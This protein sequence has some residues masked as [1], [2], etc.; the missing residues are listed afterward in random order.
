MCSLLLAGVAG[1]NEDLRFGLGVSRPWD[2]DGMRRRGGII[3]G[4]CRH[5]L[6]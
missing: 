3:V 4:P 6:S 1:L 5:S 2:L